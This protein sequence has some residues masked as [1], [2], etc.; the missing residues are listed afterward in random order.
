[1]LTEPHI[2]RYGGLVAIPRKRTRRKKVKIEIGE[3]Y[4]CTPHSWETWK[5]PFRAVVER[6]YT[7]SAMVLIT[8]THPSD[9]Y[10]LQQLQNRTVVPLKGMVAA[11]D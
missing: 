1:M 7:N 8:A 11:D 9:E 3:V 2:S 10:L 6:I 4:E 5:Y